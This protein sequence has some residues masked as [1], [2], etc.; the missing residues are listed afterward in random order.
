MEQRQ[1][2]TEEEEPERE[3]RHH[4][5]LYRAFLL[6]VLGLFGTPLT[7]SMPPVLAQ[8]TE[9]S[10]A[11]VWSPRDDEDLLGLS[12]QVSSLETGRGDPEAIAKRESFLEALK[13]FE[14][15]ESKHIGD[16]AEFVIDAYIHLERKRG[17]KDGEIA[18][19]VRRMREW[20]NLL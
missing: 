9:V 15:A 11:Q 2:M 20:L 12:H 13:I 18:E 8:P 7:L 6:G 10:V 5:L 1:E 4:S 17:K 16:A 3:H 19:D 14:I